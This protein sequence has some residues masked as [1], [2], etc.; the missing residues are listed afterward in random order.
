MKPMTIGQVSKESGVGIETVR[1]YEREGLI[2]KPDRSASG[3]RQFD[4]TTIDRLHFI[5]RAKELGFTLGEIKELFDL[6]VDPTT[7]CA[8]VKNKADAKVADIDGKIRS[9][10]RMKKALVRLTKACGENVKTS[11]CPILDA[12][13]RRPK[14]STKETNT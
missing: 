8:D 1:F 3:Y 4:E 10:Q 7:S 14:R 12:L 6:R 13:E 11:E 9:L 5:Q 2:P